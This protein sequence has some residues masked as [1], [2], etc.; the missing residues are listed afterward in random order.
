MDDLDPLPHAGHAAIV[1]SPFAHARIVA[2]D[3]SA[4]LACEGVLGRRDRRRGRRA[5][6]ALSRRPSER[7]STTAPPR[8][9]SPA[10]SASRS[11]SSSRA[12]ATW[13]RTR[14]S[15]C[16]ST[17]TRCRPPR[18]RRRRWPTA[19][20]CCTRRS[21]ATWRRIAASATAIPRARS[22]ARRSIVRERFRHPRSSATPVE[23]YGVIA[24]WD[25]A[26]G[27][28]TAWANFQGPFTLHGVAAAALGI[29][30]S[31]LRLCTPA[32]SGG[33]YGIKS[34]VYA[35]VVLMAVVSRML[36]VPVRWTED[37]ARAPSRL[38]DGDGAADR[39]RGGIRPGRQAARRCASTS[40]TTSA[41]TC[42]RPSRPRST[43]C[44]AA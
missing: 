29:P 5:L 18:A 26:A 9:R 39:S 31:R 8:T 3:V 11:P 42:G 7:G 21:A 23:C 34:A 35:Y 12:I 36:G 41:P 24:S 43:A 15:A 1:R 22:R 13:P 14:P 32:D 17:T 25:A 2:V 44:T 38:L 37:R 16:S 6:A 33:S 20:R 30:G 40:S 19:R 4:A 28:V 10:T 27:G